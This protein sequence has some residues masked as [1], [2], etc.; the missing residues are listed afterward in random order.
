MAARPLALV[1]KP[2]ALKRLL[3]EQLRPILE[4]RSIR[5]AVV[6][7]LLIMAS[8]LSLIPDPWGVH[9][10]DAGWMFM[11]AVSV[12]AI[13]AGLRDG[14]MVAITASL[15]DAL[16]MSTSSHGLDMTIF[17]SVSASRFA[18]YG[19]TAILLGAF[20]EA[21]HSVQSHLRELASIDPLTKVANLARFKHEIAFLEATDS[22]FT[23]IV[24][25]VDNLKFINDKYG[26]PV[27]SL[28]IQKVANALRRVVRASDCV[29][30]YGGDEFVVIL[31]EADRAGAQIA[32][33]R[34]RVML[35]EE[36]LPSAPEMQLSVSVGTAVHGEDGDNADELLEAADQEM[37][38]DKRTRKAS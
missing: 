27:G 9:V 22:H 11:V 2:G 7:S 35:Q 37:Y 10:I 25:D 14:L 18:L 16:Y 20:A 33:N 26:H 13:A 34:L 28:A 3:T 30:R 15:L 32:V 21:H 23:V 8:L 4:R 24:V 6:G 29:A 5:Y 38:L 1:N 31:K 17:A 12:S 36:T 19:I